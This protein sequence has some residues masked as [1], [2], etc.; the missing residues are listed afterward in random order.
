MVSFFPENFISDAVQ[1]QRVVE[2]KAA[3][4]LSARI[5]TATVGCAATHFHVNILVFLR[6]FLLSI[7][8]HFFRADL[9]SPQAKWERAQRTFADSR[10]GV[11]RVPDYFKLQDRLN[12]AVI[13]R[14]ELLQ[15][16]RQQQQRA[17][18]RNDAMNRAQNSASKLIAELDIA[19]TTPTFR[20]L[21]LPPAPTIEDSILTLH[22]LPQLHGHL[23]HRTTVTASSSAD[24]G[25]DA[26]EHFFAWLRAGNGSCNNPSV[27]AF[28]SAFSRAATAATL[29]LGDSQ[30]NVFAPAHTVLAKRDRQPRD[31]ALL[32]PRPSFRAALLAA[33]AQRARDPAAPP[34]TAS[35]AA[36]CA[37]PPPSSSAGAALS[38]D[39]WAIEPDDELILMLSGFAPARQ[40]VD[41][42]NVARQ[43]QHH[44]AVCRIL[45]YCLRVATSLAHRHTSSGERE[46]A[47]LAHAMLSLLDTLCAPT[48]IAIGARPTLQHV[49]AAVA[50]GTLLSAGALPLV[51]A[52]STVVAPS[53]LG[54]A[55]SARRRRP[56]VSTD[57]AS[58]V[59]LNGV[60]APTAATVDF[61]TALAATLADSCNN[62]SLARGGVD[63]FIDLTY[64]LL[65][66][67][68]L[69]DRWARAL[70]S[71][72]PATANSVFSLAAVSAAVH[73]V[74]VRQ[75]AR[76]F[77]TAWLRRNVATAPRA[78]LSLR[79]GLRAATSAPAAAGNS[80]TVSSST[81]MSA[82][83]SPAPPVITPA[84]M[85]ESSAAATPSTA[86]SRSKKRGKA[87]ADGVQRKRAVR[88]QK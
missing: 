11:A 45:G 14:D 15:Q 69:Q 67:G 78:A 31:L 47:Q 26:M 44:S 40:R 27:A 68:A 35:V 50:S 29:S 23:L 17:L 66:D 80:A 62:L 30:R 43:Q 61:A 74:V 6:F 42:G 39:E 8:P 1:R 48:H 55:I 32:S 70:P 72:L 64:T 28:A 58:A 13:T 2:Q 83:S 20:S 53:A 12:S 37:A 60:L 5:A 82:A 59:P 81:S 49:D 3:A 7:T 85:S 88:V 65:G 9:P 46:H 41:G 4:A 75:F 86:D 76:T 54:P 52:P 77:V 21:F 87:S 18:A 10:D 56:R 36:L 25:S 24:V 38:S 57:A 34:A 73:C 63:Y 84:A 79:T 33:T 19:A 22:A 16:Q 51:P 71:S